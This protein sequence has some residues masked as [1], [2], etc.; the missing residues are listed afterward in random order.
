MS[1]DAFPR[2]SL[3]VLPTPLVR[4]PRLEASLGPGSPRIWL[5]RD[6][7]TGLALGG[8][9]ARKL[10]FLVAGALGDG[11][12]VLITEGAVQSNHARMTA[13]AANVSGLRCALVLDAANGDTVAGN[14][15]LD[16]LLGA[17][18]HIVPGPADRAPAME[19]LASALREQGEIPCLVPTGGSVPLGALGYVAA[20]GELMAQLEAVGESPRA[21]YHATGSLGTQAGLVVGA[22]LHGAPFAI[23]GIAV[24]H[25]AAA[26]P[27]RGAVLAN[28]TAALA[29]LDAI[30]T[31]TDF[32]V[33]G[34]YIGEAYGKRTPG[35]LEA[36]RLL[37]NTEGVLLDPV[38]SGKAMAGMIDHIRA[39]RYSAGESVVFLHTGGA[40]ALFAHGEALL[41]RP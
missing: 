10:E 25:P 38:Y 28:E 13:A 8:N 22:R 6:D 7:L 27:A 39:G 16:H 21:L 4:A 41:G 18:V 35:C 17:E 32:R 5:K 1:V 37:G 3:C 14:L 40:P 20:V 12:T 33:D 26:K 31:E 29:G 11:A 2:A 34:G 19:R 30:F 15:L 36:I 24:S 23:E 9:K